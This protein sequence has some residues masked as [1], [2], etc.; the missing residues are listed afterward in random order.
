[1]MERND[2]I[3]PEIFG[4]LGGGGR[5]GSLTRGSDGRSGRS[6]R[7]GRAGRTGIAGR[8]R[9]A[10]IDPIDKF[11]RLGRRIGEIR[12]TKLGI[13]ILIPSL[14]SERSRTISGHF[15]NLS[16]GID[17]MSIER[18]LNFQYWRL[19]RS[20]RHTLHVALVSA[21]ISRSGCHQSAIAL[22]S[23]NSSAHLRNLTPLS[24]S[25]P[26][27]ICCMVLILQRI[28]AI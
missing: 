26:P 2:E 20:L 1:M 14:I 13:E 27:V 10:L 15:G 24:R 8:S 22:I 3:D 9:D 16:T 21:N 18:S 28:C 7:G 23:T 4:S 17:G 6:G 11:G 25:Q 12:G 5:S 19:L